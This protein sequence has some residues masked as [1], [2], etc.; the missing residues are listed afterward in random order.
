MISDLIALVPVHLIIDLDYSFVVMMHVVIVVGV[1]T[2][3]IIRFWSLRLMVT[4]REIEPRWTPP[5]TIVRES[6]KSR[7]NVETC[8]IKWLRKERSWVLESGAI[9]LSIVEWTLLCAVTVGG[10]AIRK[11]AVLL[12]RLACPDADLPF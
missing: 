1:D 4:G 7:G 10:L 9:V 5:W 2:W 3:T 12:R 11:L 8:T 6:P